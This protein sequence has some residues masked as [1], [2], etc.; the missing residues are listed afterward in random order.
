MLRDRMPRTLSL[1]LKWCKAKERWLNY[2]YDNHI[3]TVSKDL[4]GTRVKQCLG[5]R[6]RYDVNDLHA[7]LWQGGVSHKKINDFVYA[8]TPQELNDMFTLEFKDTILWDKLNDKDTLYWSRVAS[9]VAWFRST[10]LYIE[11]AYKT[12]REVA[13]KNEFDT[14]VE[15]INHYLKSLLPKDEDSIEIKRAKITYVNKL[16]D[17]LVDSFEGRI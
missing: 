7:Y 6:K 12:S 2:V 8:C 4:R 10:H 5:I 14:K 1:A 17:Y 3:K 15:I 13:G 11:N 9:W 16:V